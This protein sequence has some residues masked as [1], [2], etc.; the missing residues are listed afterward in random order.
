LPTG[1]RKKDARKLFARVLADAK[2]HSDRINGFKLRDA[3]L[4]AKDWLVIVGV[5]ATTRVRLKIVK[6]GGAADFDFRSRDRMNEWDPQNDSDVRRLTGDGTAPFEGAIPSFVP[7][8]SL[9]CVTPKDFGYWE[10]GDRVL[11]KVAGFHG[12]MPN[13]NMLHRLLVR[14][15]TERPDRRGNTWGRRAPGVK[16]WQPPLRL[17]E[18]T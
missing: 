13:M 11:M 3:G 15:F 4:T 8:K 9:V 6:R 2:K 10:V 5:D 16:N 17:R 1:Q 12:I 18:K 7:E 14:F